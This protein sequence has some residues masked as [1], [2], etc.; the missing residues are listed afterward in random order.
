ME[1]NSVLK[2]ELVIILIKIL[3]I[4]LLVKQFGHC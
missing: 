1:Y 2:T 3:V 4:G